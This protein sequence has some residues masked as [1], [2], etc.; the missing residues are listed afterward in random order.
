MRIDTGD[1]A[2]VLVSAALVMFMTPGLALFYGGLVRAKRPSGQGDSDGGCAHR[3]GRRAT[4]GPGN[5]F[6]PTVLVDIPRDSPAYRDELFGPVAAVFRVPLADEAIRLTNIRRS[7]SARACGPTMMLSASASCAARDRPGLRQRHGR[8]GST[9]AFWRGEALGLRP[10]ARG[11]RHPRVRQRQDRVGGELKRHAAQSSSPRRA[12]STRS[13]TSLHLCA[14]G[15]LGGERLLTP[16]IPLQSAAPQ[17]LNSSSR[18]SWPHSSRARRSGRPSQHPLHHDRRPRGARHQRLRVARQPDAEPRPPRARGRAASTNVFATNSICTPSRAAILTGQYS[19]LNGVTMFNRFDS[20]R[21]TVARLLQQGG[22]HTGM[23]GKWHLGSDPAGFDRWEILPGQGAYV[24]PGLLH[25]DRR[26]DVHRPLRHRRHHRPRASTSSTKR[27]RDK[28]FFLMMHHKAPHRPWE[29]DADARARS[30]PTQRI[31][32]PATFW[33]DVR[34]AHRR[35]AREP[36]ARRRRPDQPRPQARRRRRASAA[37]T[38]HQLARDASRTRSRSCATA[39]RDAHRRGARRAGST[40]A[41]CRTTSR[42]CSRSTT[43]S[44]ACSTTSTRPASRGTR[45]SS[46]PATRAS[47]SATTA[48]STSASCTR[49]R[50]GCRSSS[51][52]RRRSSPGTRSDAIG[53]QRRLRADVPRRRRPA[54]SGRHA[55]P[56]PAAGAARA[57][58]G[59]L[60]D[61]D[62]LPLLPR[63]RRPQHARALRRA[64]ARRT[65]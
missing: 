19:H 3:Y 5:Y 36:A 65:S 41:T 55:G 20:S 48:C 8:L 1:T 45:S 26:E 2:W 24:D 62:V 49:S 61:V 57:H 60:A 43:T 29:P 13:Q 42:P 22:Y 51:A 12:P 39:R 14:L 54:A 44:A 15:A 11:A 23:I 38:L 47:S 32:E 35:A 33:D 37:P 52:G 30:S 18:R 7:V 16:G 9:R 4:P 17:C 64:H 27:P 21:M 63:P 50:S 40:S 10:G 59:R 58:A 34:D 53:A 6:A 56:Q 28:P 31:P 25:G 46:T